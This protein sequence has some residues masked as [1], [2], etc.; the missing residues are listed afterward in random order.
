[1]DLP[2][3]RDALMECPEEDLSEMRDYDQRTPLHVAATNGSV[4]IVRFLLHR[5][6]KVNS[7]DRWGQTPMFEAVTHL[8]SKVVKILAA[9]AGRL[10]M[11]G[12]ELACFI[13]KMVMLKN[14][15]ILQLASLAQDFTTKC[16]DYDD[17][18]PLHVAGDLGYSHIYVFLIE[19]GADT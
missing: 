15:E 4:E 14:L 10:E 2:R 18:T 17:R 8:Q 7:V 11:Q 16:A 12:M 13:N 9:H 1:M 5:G 3:L 6:A 19:K